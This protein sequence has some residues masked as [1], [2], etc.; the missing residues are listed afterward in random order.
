MQV[1]R[2]LTDEDKQTNMMDILTRYTRLCKKLC[3]KNS[4][5]FDRHD[6]SCPFELVEDKN[7]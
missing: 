2:E 1:K 5:A 4:P 3:F 6:H 7:D